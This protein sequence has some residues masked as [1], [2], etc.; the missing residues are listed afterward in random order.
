MNLA[1]TLLKMFVESHGAMHNNQR[2]GSFGIMSNFSFYY[3][4][5]MSTIEG[6]MVSTNDEN[7]Y[8]VKNA[9]CSWNGKEAAQDSTKMR[10]IQENPTLNEKFI[11]AF[12]SYNM[13]NN[14]IGGILGRSQ[15]KR[16]DANNEIRSRNQDFFLSSINPEAFHID[17]ETEGSS[18]YAFN[19]I[20]RGKKRRSNGSTFTSTRN[21]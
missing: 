13:R 20:L 16:L 12:P 10:Y 3:A 11:F 7:I 15:L 17:F 4:H 6:G 2:L 1:Y 5:H 18:N 14:E 21:E 19:L 8:E 9:S